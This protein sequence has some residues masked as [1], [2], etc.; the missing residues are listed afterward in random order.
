MMNTQEDES[1]ILR[2]V[3]LLAL[4]NR[5]DNSIDSTLSELDEVGAMS[6]KES[7]QLLKELK[8]ENLISNG[9]LTPLGIA[10]VEEAKK[11]FKI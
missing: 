11:F 4:Q 8:S 10:E 3:L 2:R 5:E 7:K 1:V 6:L 9:Q